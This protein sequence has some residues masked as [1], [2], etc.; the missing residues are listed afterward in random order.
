MKWNALC[1]FILLILWRCNKILQNMHKYK[2]EKSYEYSRNT[3]IKSRSIFLHSMVALCWLDAS[4]FC[5]LLIGREVVTNDSKMK[6][7]AKKYKYICNLRPQNRDILANLNTNTA[8]Q[9]STIII[10]TQGG[11]AVVTN[12]GKLECLSFLPSPLCRLFSTNCQECVF[13]VQCPA[14]VMFLVT[15]VAQ[16]A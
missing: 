9:K 16:S 3:H 4:D 14:L 12:D 7:T 15:F 10:V 11:R 8:T 13:F 2:S 6:K 1:W 5:W